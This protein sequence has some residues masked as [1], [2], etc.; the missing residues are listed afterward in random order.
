MFLAQ[1]SIQFYVMIEG[2]VLYHK[3]RELV[4]PSKDAIELSQ[5]DDSFK[6]SAQ[7]RLEAIRMLF[8]TEIYK[9]HI[10]FVYLQT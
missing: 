10:I 9:M 6:T 2:F 1:F 8:S 5:K 7:K 4:I 3:W